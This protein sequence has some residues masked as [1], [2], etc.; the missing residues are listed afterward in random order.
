MKRRNWIFTLLGLP[1]AAQKSQVAPGTTLGHVIYS[2]P[3]WRLEVEGKPE[4][5]QCPVCGLIADSYRPN[6]QFCGDYN[7]GQQETSLGM[8]GCDPKVTIVRCKRCSAAFWQRQI[9]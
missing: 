4:N 1:L 8:H 7:I 6:T 5:G 2:P 9:S 3:Q